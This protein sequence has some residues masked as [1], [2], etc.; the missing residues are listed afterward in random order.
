VDFRLQ[1]NHVVSLPSRS[2]LRL[3]AKI[4]RLIFAY[5]GY[6]CRHGGVDIISRH[7]YVCVPSAKRCRMSSVALIAQLTCVCAVEDM[8]AIVFV[9]VK[10]LRQR[11]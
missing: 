10:A 1:T 6:I 8:W 11:Q 2:R 5:L 4:A 3:E 9:R 7:F